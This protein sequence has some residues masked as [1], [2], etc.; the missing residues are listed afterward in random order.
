[1]ATSEINSKRTTLSPR[2][3][4]ENEPHK[5]EISRQIFANQNEFDDDDD[6]QLAILSPE[7]N[8]G[9]PDDDCSTSLVRVPNEEP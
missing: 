7:S 4:L 1:M 2:D 5:C 9:G 8:S 3:C 6:E